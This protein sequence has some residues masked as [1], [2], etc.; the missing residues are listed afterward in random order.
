MLKTGWIRKHGRKADTSRMSD[1]DIEAQIA[2]L[3]RLKDKRKSVGVFDPQ[4]LA[5]AVAAVEGGR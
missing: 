4:A 2:Q 3:T 5:A 1:A